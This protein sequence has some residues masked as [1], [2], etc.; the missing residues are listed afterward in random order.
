MAKHYKKFREYHMGKL[1]DPAEAKAYLEMALE[2]LHKEGDREGFL[3]ALRDVT[4][5]QGGVTQLL[6]QTKLKPAGVY[7]ALSEDGNPTLS[8]LDRI[9]GG[10]GLRL[11]IEPTDTPPASL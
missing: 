7:K 8:T 10:L 2:D 11:S 3:L 5:A 4:E 6:E 9:L 1:S